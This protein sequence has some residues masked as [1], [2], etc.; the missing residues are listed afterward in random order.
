MSS[1]E[2]IAAKDYVAETGCSLSEAKNALTKAMAHL[3]F[4]RDNEAYIDKL[5]AA[6]DEALEAARGRPDSTAKLIDS[7][8]KLRGYIPSSGAHI[9]IQVGVMLAERAPNLMRLLGEVVGVG[10]RSRF[11]SR[12]V[13]LGQTEEAAASMADVLVQD[14]MEALVERAGDVAAELKGEERR[15]ALPGGR[16]GG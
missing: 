7:M 13:A 9:D 6:G 11:V 12:F 1:G 14:V 2:T 4:I 16:S 3:A 15:L 10:A 5:N 8:G